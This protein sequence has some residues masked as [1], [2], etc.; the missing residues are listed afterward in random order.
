MADD[1]AAIDPA[2][3]YLVK[4]TTLRKLLK[5]KVKVNKEHLLTR[6]EADGVQFMEFANVVKMYGIWNGALAVWETPAKRVN[7]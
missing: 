2:K 1:A 3:T 6:E 4:G 7:L 5:R